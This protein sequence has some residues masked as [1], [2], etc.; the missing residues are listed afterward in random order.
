MNEA[1]ADARKYRVF[2]Q[3]ALRRRIFCRRGFA[4]FSGGFRAG[5]NPPPTSRPFLDELNRET[6]VLFNQASP[7]VVRL[8]LPIASFAMDDEL[9]NKW[10]DRLDPEVRRRLEELEN[11]G[12]AEGLVREDIVPTT[13]PSNP[14]GDTTAPSVIEMQLRC[15]RP[16]ASA[17]S[18]TI[19]GMFWFRSSLI[20]VNSL[21]RRSSYCRMGR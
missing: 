21:R 3:G 7:S 18:S 8:Q 6:Q 12:P 5:D 2:R 16:I 13:L 1:N 4:D 11:R 9:L 10:S 15:L 19:N 17:L 14:G 20:R